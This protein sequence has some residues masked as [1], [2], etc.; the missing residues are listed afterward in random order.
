MIQLDV[1]SY[2]KWFL[3]QRWIIITISNDSIVW[4]LPAK[5]IQF[6]VSKPPLLFGQGSIIRICQKNI[7]IKKFTA[8]VWHGIS[9]NLFED[10]NVKKICSKR[11]KTRKN[12]KMYY[13][14][15]KLFQKSCNLLSGATFE[16]Q[17]LTF[18]NWTRLFLLL[19]LYHKDLM[20]IIVKF[21]SSSI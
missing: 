1:W 3:S 10:K 16:Q 6:S 15:K 20:K 18:G 14:I 12:E 7:P 9:S 2:L 21:F 17:I 4:V 19:R 11:V 13:K 5:L 8:K